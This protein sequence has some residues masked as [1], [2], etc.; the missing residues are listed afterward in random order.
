MLRKATFAALM[1]AALVIV[2]SAAMAQSASWDEDEDDA[3]YS[4]PYYGYDEQPGYRQYYDD[5]YDTGYGG[6]GFSITFGTGSGY[7]QPYYNRG[8]YADDGYYGYYG[9]NYYQNGYSRNEGRYYRNHYRNQHGRCGS[10]ATGAIVGGAVGALV[11]REIGRSANEN[12]DGYRSGGTTGAI[13]G[14]AAGALAGRAIDQD[15]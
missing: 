9:N 15:C 13:V 6:V 11:G 10:G 2:P 4:Q 1:G 3:E 12:R 8:G 5:G 14:G 7:A